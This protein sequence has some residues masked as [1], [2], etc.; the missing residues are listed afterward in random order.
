MEMQVRS[1][2]LSKGVCC[3]DSCNIQLLTTW[4]VLALLVLEKMLAA[5]SGQ[6]VVS[7]E[8]RCIISLC[9]KALMNVKVIKMS[10]N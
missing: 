8:N 7:T 4:A 3:R 10:I 2:F 9:L 1:E 5:L 6:G